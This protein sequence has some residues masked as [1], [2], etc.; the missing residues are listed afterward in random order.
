MKDLSTLLTVCLT[1][2]ALPCAKVLG[3]EELTPA[4]ATMEVVASGVGLDPDKAL[5]DA[6][7]NAVQQVVG[8]IVDAETLIKNDDI[9]KD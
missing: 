6:L 7:M 5:K 8:A 2:I 3:A 1:L 4:A 9:V